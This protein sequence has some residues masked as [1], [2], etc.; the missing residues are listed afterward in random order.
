ME[1]WWFILIEA[2]VIW[3]GNC[4]RLRLLTCPAGDGR[5]FFGSLR[6]L[7]A[8][9]TVLWRWRWISASS[10]FHSLSWAGPFMSRP[11]S[12]IC[13]TL[14][15]TVATSVLS[16]MQPEIEFLPTGYIC[17]TFI[18]LPAS[19]LSRYLAASLAPYTSA[20]STAMCLRRASFSF[21]SILTSASSFTSF[22][23]SFLL[24]SSSFS[25]SRDKGC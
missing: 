4:L 7:Q 17:N 14:Q 5:G 20:C 24:A 21:L 23:F 1:H 8:R 10:W 11:N 3:V 25:C 15:N 22:T 6:P 16:T 2:L 9:M 18:Y 12:W 19:S 13:W